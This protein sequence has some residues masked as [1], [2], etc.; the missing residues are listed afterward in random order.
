MTPIRRFITKATHC[1][2]GLQLICSTHARA[3]AENSNPV[4]SSESS[5]GN[6]CEILSISQQGAMLKTFLEQLENSIRTNNMAGFYELLHPAVIRTEEEK[7]AEFNNMMSSYE[8]RGKNLQRNFIYQLEFARTP[9]EV[10]CGKHRINGVSG[11]TKQWAIEY[12]TVTNREQVRISFLFAQVPQALAAKTKHPIGIVYLNTRNWSFGG[13]TPGTL[14]EEARKWSLLNEPLASWTYGTAAK[15]IALSNA[16]FFD[17]SFQKNLDELEKVEEKKN[18]LVKDYLE[19]AVDK[20]N[21]RIKEFTVV[22]KETKPEVGI[23]AAV[24]KEI[25]VNDQIKQCKELTKMVAPLFVG[26]RNAL[27]G[28][29][30]MIYKIDDPIA[31]IPRYGSIFTRFTE[32]LGN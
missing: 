15:R 28:I 29:E 24:D 7:T 2:L 19:K 14:F 6:S 21:L 12:S 9:H 30:C 20:T 31:Q 16:Y 11:P 17:T 4:N 10:S 32:A 25:P 8:L 23:K 5:K 27:D 22:F 3:Q 13:K 18:N 26:A 1:T